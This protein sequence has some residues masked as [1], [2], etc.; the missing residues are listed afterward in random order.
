ELVEVVDP[1]ARLYSG[2][3]SLERLP[4]G[5]AVH[6]AERR[7]RQHEVARGASRPKRGHHRE[8]GRLRLDLVRAQVEAGPDEDIPEALD[9]IV[10][11]AVPAQEGAEGLV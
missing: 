6:L 7:G 8:P 1:H 4:G 5:V 11:L 9:R 10:I 3:G 2:A